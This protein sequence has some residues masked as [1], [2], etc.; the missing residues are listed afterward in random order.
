[1][2][3]SYT[4]SEDK[5]LEDIA[6]LLESNDLPPWRKPWAGHQ[7]EHRNLITGKPY[8]GVNP[9]LLEVGLLLR[10]TNC[11]LWCSGARC[12][13]WLPTN[14]NPPLRNRLAPCLSGVG[15]YPE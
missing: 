6:A 11:P 9:L 12:R 7:G 4:S 15:I 3:K 10:E 2:T 8:Q 14:S 5:L 1:M 13:G